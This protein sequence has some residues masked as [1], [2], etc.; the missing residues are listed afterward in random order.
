MRRTRTRK[1]QQQRKKTT[2]GPAKLT[3]QTRS[4]GDGVRTEQEKEA[5]TQKA[6]E[7][8]EPTAVGGST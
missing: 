2:K 3:E 7:E 6:E 5:S 8:A 1:K 4:I